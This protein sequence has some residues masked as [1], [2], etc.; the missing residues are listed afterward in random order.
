MLEKIDIVTKDILH[1][2][3][4]DVSLKIDAVYR[5]GLSFESAKAE[6][7]GKVLEATA[8]GMIGGSNEQLR[9]ASAYTQ[10]KGEYD[11]V[12]LLEKAH[13][14]NTNS[15]AVA[16]IALSFARDCLRIEEIANRINVERS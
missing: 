7:E 14:A 4:E 6:L 11:N 9:K 1:K 2:A 3:Y 8:A 12:D 16:Q 5:S 15:L 10:F 13:K